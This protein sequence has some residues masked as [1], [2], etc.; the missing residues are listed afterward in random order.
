[1][2]GHFRDLLDWIYNHIGFSG[3]FASIALF[4]LALLVPFVVLRRQTRRR[5]LPKWSWLT[6]SATIV[7]GLMFYVTRLRF[8]EWVWPVV[9][10]TK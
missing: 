3:A 4:A 2:N 10:D 6:F 8:I 5:T 9:V 1:M 7:S